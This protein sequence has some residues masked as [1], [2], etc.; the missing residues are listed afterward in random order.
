MEQ[1]TEPLNDND[2]QDLDKRRSWVFGSKSSASDFPSVDAKLDLLAAMLES[3]VLTPKHEWE[4]CSLGV[5]FGDTLVQATDFIWVAV[6]DEYG[7]SPALMVPG[8]QIRLFPMTTLLRRMEDGEKIDI[9][10]LFVGF[11]ERAAVLR[12]RDTPQH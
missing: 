8:S 6:H 11:C 5:I 9:R 3:G 12:K 4:L 2:I 1:K 7:R 10:D